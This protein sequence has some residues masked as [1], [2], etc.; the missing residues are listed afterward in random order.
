MQ[1]NF[2]NKPEIDS[3]YFGI[4]EDTF[5][6]LDSNEDELQ[7]LEEKNS[8]EDEYESYDKVNKE[9]FDKKT[10]LNEKVKYVVMNTGYGSRIINHLIQG[11]I[12]NQELD[13]YDSGLKLMAVFDNLWSKNN[14][15][16]N[17][18]YIHDI[19]NKERKMIKSFLT[20][21]DLNSIIIYRVNEEIYTDKYNMLKQYFQYFKEKPYCAF[22]SL[23]N[24]YREYYSTKYN[25]YYFYI[26]CESG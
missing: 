12:F 21:Q 10:N 13:I 7:S 1:T 6:D 3:G 17:I 26:D 5:S 8:N 24:I 20:K 22:H 15:L 16:Y 4:D 25:M 9:I 2:R 18:Y 19:T 11:R 23:D 14:D